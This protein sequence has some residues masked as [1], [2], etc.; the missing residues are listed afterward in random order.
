MKHFHIYRGLTLALAY[1]SPQVLFVVACC[2]F[3]IATYVSMHLSLC[4][5]VW[6]VG[7]RTCVCGWGF[8]AC[9]IY[10]HLWQTWFT[11][12]FLCVHLSLW[13]H[14]CSTYVL[15]CIVT[16]SHTTHMQAHPT[17]H[18]MPILFCVLLI[19]S[20]LYKCE[21]HQHVIDVMKQWGPP[22]VD[23]LAISVCFNL[24]LAS[25]CC[26]LHHKQPLSSHSTTTAP[27]LMYVYTH[28]DRSAHKCTCTHASMHTSKFVD[29]CTYICTSQHPMS[30]C[31]CMSTPCTHKHKCLQHER[32]HSQYILQRHT[33]CRE[34]HACIHSSWW[35][36][37]SCCM[38]SQIVSCQP[39]QYI[40]SL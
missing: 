33:A 8:H 20:Y 34:C 40:L 16:H 7:V 31:T 5:D 28:M 3:S 22:K 1:E 12:I 4:V 18:P 25:W 13:V 37:C 26:N 17:N 21:S 10:V 32:I 2:V 36:I 19:T 23:L 35:L 6:T 29:I 39:M 30:P 38:Y 15:Y 24:L 9:S 11:W 14:V 27:L